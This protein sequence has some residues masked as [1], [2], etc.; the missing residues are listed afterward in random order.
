MLLKKLY[1]LGMKEDAGG[2]ES[3]KKFVRKNLSVQ[4]QEYLVSRGGVLER[5]VD[6][7]ARA[8][9]Y[10]IGGDESLCSLDG[11]RKCALDNVISY[12]F[13][14]ETSKLALEFYKSRGVAIIFQC[15]DHK[16]EEL[17]TEPH[18]LFHQKWW[19]N[20]FRKS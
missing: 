7:L 16:F 17:K 18:D 9:C 19:E 8:L 3:I 20:K 1:L 6:I 10:Y 13:L 2:Y 11:L 4:V 14:R 5:E 15:S 12:A